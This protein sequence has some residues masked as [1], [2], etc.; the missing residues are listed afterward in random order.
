[1]L[2]KNLAPFGDAVTTVHGAVWSKETGLTFEERDFRDRLSWSVRVREVAPGEKADVKGYDIP[3]LMR[4]AGAERIALL[5]V[6]IERGEI[7]L[8]GGSAS[9]PA[10]GFPEWISRCDNIVIELHDEECE[11]VFYAAIEGQGFSV[12]SDGEIVICSRT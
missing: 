2:E 4:M 6:D 5:K 12:R 1:M 7:E 11:R 8:F 3:L 9:V 10:P